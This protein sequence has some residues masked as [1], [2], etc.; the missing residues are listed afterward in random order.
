MCSSQTSST[1]HNIRCS[2]PSTPPLLLSDGLN[3]LCLSTAKPPSHSPYLSSLKRR[4]WVGYGENRVLLETLVMMTDRAEF[5]RRHKANWT[6]FKTI[7]TN[8]TNKLESSEKIFLSV[9]TKNQLMLL[10]MFLVLKLCKASKLEGIVETSMDIS[11]F[12]GFVSIFHCSWVFR[13]WAA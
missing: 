1:T 13:F 5:V 7:Y 10:L 8:Q 2:C 6:H 9:Y 4:E 11:C 3:T 12:G